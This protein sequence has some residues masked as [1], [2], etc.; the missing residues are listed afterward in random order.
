MHMHMRMHMHM[1]MHMHMRMRMRMRKGGERSEVVW[2]VRGG[3]RCTFSS[4]LVPLAF[5]S[6]RRSSCLSLFAADRF[7]FVAR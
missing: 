7:Q 5:S 6:K 3:V 2:E 4:S 1:H